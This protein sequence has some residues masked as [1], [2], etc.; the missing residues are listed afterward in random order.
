MNQPQAITLWIRQL[1]HGDADAAQKL[2]EAYFRRMVGLAR[3]KL[4][5]S[6]RAAADEEDVALSAFRSFCIGARDGRFSQLVDRDNLWPLLMA[7]TANKSVDLIRRTN[8]Q[9]RGGTGKGSRSP[10]GGPSNAPSEESSDSPSGSARPIAAPLSELISRE[11]TPEFAAQLSDQLQYLLKLL[12]SLGDPD[13]QRIAL[14][15]MDGCGTAEIAEQLG[16]ARRTVERK[17][18]I[19]MKA[20]EKELETQDTD[21]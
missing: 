6:P 14:L 20:W 5:N 17:M 3:Q 8:R 2:W 15:K 10:A 7:I 16:C 11:P 18:Q 1:K 12:N 19:I 4:E 13:L 9:K 21:Q